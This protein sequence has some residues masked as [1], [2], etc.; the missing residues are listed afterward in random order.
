V[1]A[2]PVE[3]ERFAAMFARC[4]D[5]VFAY[6]RRHSD[7]VLAE[8]VA[9]E[10]FL[11]AWRRRAD[12]PED[13]LPWLLVVARN[14]LANRQR[15]LIR[16]QRLEIEL[17]ALHRLAAHSPAVEF[18]VVQ[19]SIMLRAL[20]SLTSLEREAV[21]LVAWDGLTS[22]DAATVAGCSERAFNVRLH[23][24]RRRLSRVIDA[25]DNAEPSSDSPLDQL[26]EE[27]R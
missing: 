15:S 7:A 19:R 21:L 2:S 26:L 12:L 1:S 11:I 9:A 5:P 27:R 22:R 13:P 14:T 17:I 25:A 24:A 18:E 20:T 3:T 4:S 23:R 6:A 8:D 10:T 16:A